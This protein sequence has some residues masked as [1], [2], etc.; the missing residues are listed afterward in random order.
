MRYQADVSRGHKDDARTY[1]RAGDMKCVI[2]ET[3]G[4]GSHM[5]VPSWHGDIQSVKTDA[6]IPAN[7]QEIISIPRKQKKLPDLPS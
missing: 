7:A 4:I 3:D 6:I 5:D 2:E 1:L